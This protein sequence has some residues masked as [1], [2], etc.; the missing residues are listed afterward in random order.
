LYQS[1]YLYR[2]VDRDGNTIDFLLDAKRD[3]VAA[4]RAEH[5]HGLAAVRKLSNVQS[6]RVVFVAIQF[7]CNVARVLGL[8]MH[9]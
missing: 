9:D 3:K 6:K 5:G 7:E 2:S 4:R 1:P 8:H